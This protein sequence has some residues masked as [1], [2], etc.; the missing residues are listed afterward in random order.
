MRR[1]GLR[2]FALI[3]V[4]VTLSILSLSF[5]EIHISFL[6]ANLD[7]AGSGPLGLT[8]GLDLQ[9]GAHLKYQAD[10]PDR[11]R[12]T[13]QDAV[14]ESQL[15]ELLDELGQTR[16]VL[17]KKRFT[18]DGL[19][20]G[21]AA[22]QEL[23]EALEELS[24]VDASELSEG[25]LEVSF[26][27][28]VDETD[29]RLIL[30]SAG[31][32][33]A[34][35]QSPAQ[36]QY[37]IRELLLNKGAE[38]GLRDAL[39]RKLS[40]I[41]V[42]IP[43]IEEPTKDQMKGVIDTIQR[44]V[45]AL[46][47]SEP[48]IQTLGDDRVIVQLPGA[49]GTSMDVAFLDISL[50]LAEIGA[51]L[52][53]LG[54][55]G[56]TAVSSS[57]GSAVIRTEEALTQEDRRVLEGLAQTLAP[58]LEIEAGDDENE[59]AVSFP[60]PPTELTIS[61]LLSG[62]GLTDYSVNQRPDTGNFIIRTEDVLA[63]E[64]QEQIRE[65]LEA[66]VALIVA[67]EATGGIEEAKRLIG[68]TAQL[69]FKERACEDAV[70]IDYTENIIEGLTGE[71]LIS[72]F[73]DRDPVGQ[74]IVSLQFNSR[75]TDILRQLIPR[76][77][78]MGQLGRLAIFLD[79]EEV[80]A[81]V[82]RDPTVFFD[83]SGVIT[84][85]FTNESALRLAIQLESGRLPV[86]LVLI[87]ESTVD[88]L[89]GADSLRKSLI[90]GFV[91]LCL[92]L[93]FMLAYYRMAGLVAGTALL[94]YGTIALAIFKLV[95]VTLTLSAMAGLVLSVGMAV[96]AN[97]LIFERMKEELRTGRTLA[98]S[99]EV[100]FRRAWPAIR[101][102]NVSTIITCVILWWFGARMGAPQV[103]GFG[104][105]LLIGVLV[106]MFTAIMVSRNMLQLLALTPVGKRMDLFTPEPRRQ[107]VGVVG[108]GR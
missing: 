39:G 7:A 89:L 2:V 75:G 43:R 47:T 98:S 70:C 41:V 63:T 30:N 1:R 21:D 32:F 80:S 5:R 86:P 23:T 64:D 29:L 99:M 61:G 11:V 54:H 91:G 83:G 100:G 9:G 68:Q 101:D 65:E 25:V 49:G 16:V 40:P 97:I 93:V 48:I 82:V 24:S 18:I 13:F 52:Q 106:S 51:T 33:E 74:A 42:F 19:S 69:V 105:T 103:I 20:T 14:E 59:I 62:L 73:P 31:Y 78:D 50:M 60:P 45:N 46:G 35:I 66:K 92:V 12:V 90:A 87:S 95:P 77:F 44:R 55:T 57:L 38:D 71:N 6:G 53:G 26:Q 58:G 67:F 108:G 107:P 15:L 37:T 3:F 96:D 10:L 85:G 4:I 72:A 104:V 27:N 84:G 17:A 28:T 102:G 79:Q 8:L 36:E 88:A 94:I 56:A 34:T 22:L 76:L 81:A